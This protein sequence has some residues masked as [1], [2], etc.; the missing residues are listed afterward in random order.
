M[1]YVQTHNKL[2]AFGA[3]CG[4]LCLKLFA[5]LIESKDSLQGEINLDS[6]VAHLKQ[7]LA[8]L[9][10]DGATAFT[11]DVEL[12]SAWWS[13]T[14]FVV[15]NQISLGKLDEALSQSLAAIS[16]ESDA[17]TVLRPQAQVIDA[18][19]SAIMQ[20]WAKNLTKPPPQDQLK[21]LAVN[22]DRIRQKSAEGLEAILASG[23]EPTGF[24]ALWGTTYF[25]A[26]HTLLRYAGVRGQTENIENCKCLL[27]AACDLLTP[28][29]KEEIGLNDRMAD[30]I[31]FCAF[32]YAVKKNFS[33]LTETINDLMQNHPTLGVDFYLPPLLAL[34]L[35]NTLRDVESGQIR[36]ELTALFMTLLTYFDRSGAVDSL[37]RANGTKSRTAAIALYKHLLLE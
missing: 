30:A 35:G 2:G 34:L 37:V 24:A 28:N 22:A 33:K 15:G 19:F 27:T 14:V 20:Q 21:T 13:A 1:L 31:I 25:L 10:R 18:F 3:K 17:A 4:A 12:Q 29:Q 32:G 8:R 11:T 5:L 23:V 16:E 6:G 9:C 7:Q 26:L 36:Q